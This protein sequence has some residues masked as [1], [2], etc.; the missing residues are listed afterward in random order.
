[1]ARRDEG[2]RYALTLGGQVPMSVGGLLAALLVATVA[3]TASPA[4]GG[5]LLLDVESS[6]RLLQVWRFF[7]WPFVEAPL[8]ASVFTLLFAGLMLVW[9][10]RQL[11]SAWGELVFLRRVAIIGGGAGAITALLLVPV[12]WELR[13]H[14]IWPLV[15]ALLLCWGLLYQSQRLSWFGVVEMRGLTVAR[16]IGFGTPAWAL[17]LGPPG[18]GPLERLAVYLPHLAALLLAWVLVGEGP[19]RR[20]RRIT[21]RWRE[22]RLRR[23]RSRFEVV[24]PG[25]RPPGGQWLN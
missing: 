3:G 10:G 19:R 20:W 13:V 12:G 11:T 23:A 9:L 22:A 7:T 8:P 15:N 18:M 16:V 14:G 24:D 17:L 25:P 4:L 5:W 1:M 2:L 6:A 21:G